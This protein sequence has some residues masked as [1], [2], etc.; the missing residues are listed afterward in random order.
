MA[1][2]LRKIETYKRE[3]IAAAKASV[4]V[5]EL[6]ARAQEQEAPRGFLGALAEASAPLDNLPSLPKSKRQVHRRA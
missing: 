1:D 5:D 3:E 4:P 2:I 6:K